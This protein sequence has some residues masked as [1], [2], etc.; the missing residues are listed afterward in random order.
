M[1]GISYQVDHRL[2]DQLPDGHLNMASFDQAEIQ[3]ARVVRAFFLRGHASPL[4]IADLEEFHRHLA[5]AGLCRPGDA[6]TWMLWFE[7]V[8]PDHLPLQTLGVRVEQ[9]RKGNHL[10]N[11]RVRSDMFTKELEREMNEWGV[12]LYQ[13]KT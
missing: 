5:G 1:S 4:L 6:V 12:Q 3:K 8:D 13:G 9:D 2:V 10:F 7:R 11:I